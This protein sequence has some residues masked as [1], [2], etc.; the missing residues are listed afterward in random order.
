[1]AQAW[2]RDRL[3]PRHR[4][5]L[6][7]PGADRFRRARRLHRDRHGVQPRRPAVR[8]GQGRADP[9]QPADRRRGRGHRR[10]GRDRRCRAEG[11]QPGRRRVQRDARSAI[12]TAPLSL[13][14]AADRLARPRLWIGFVAMSIGMFMAVLDIQIVASSLPEI[15]AA[16]LIPLDH[17]SWIQTAYLSAE[18]VAIP[19]TGW[20]TRSFSTRGA[21]VGC[22]LGF[23]AA[24]ALCAGA[25]SFGWLAEG[26]AGG[27]ADP[28]ILALAVLCLVSG[29]GAVRRCRS[30]AVPLVDLGAFGRRNF[31]LGC[32]FS[33]TLG[34]GLYGAT[35]LLPLFLGIVRHHDPLEIGLIML[36]TGIA[37]L[38]AAPVAAVL[39]RKSDLR[40]L[41]A[42]G[43]ALLAAGLIGNGFMTPDDD[44]WGLFWQQGARGVAFMLCLLPTTSLALNDFPL[45]EVSNASGLFNLMRNLGGAIGLAVVKTLLESRA[46]T[47]VT[48]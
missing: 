47:H 38:I 48:P 4:P 42:A 1:M 7:D 26:P 8:R 40:W 14:A 9:G 36:V 29:V 37:Q 20:V 32:W 13:A 27:W 15:Q 5:G 41:T 28:L 6:C 18:I 24:S 31:V 35:F 30:C 16:L 34:A 23:T 33:F 46:P 43:Y 17:L 3:W 39:E 22:V 12:G 19:L 10:A 45:G 2:P 21:F 11:P 44:F 25:D